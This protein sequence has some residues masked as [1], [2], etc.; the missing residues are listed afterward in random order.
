MKNSYERIEYY[1]EHNK[2]DDGLVTENTLEKNENEI[3]K[4]LN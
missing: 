4:T 1:K 2:R 3:E